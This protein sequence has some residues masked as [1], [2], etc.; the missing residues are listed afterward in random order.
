MDFNTQLSHAPYVNCTNEALTS[1]DGI[2]AL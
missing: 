1:R 2:N